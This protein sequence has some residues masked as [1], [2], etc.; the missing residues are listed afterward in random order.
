MT[1]QWHPLPGRCSKYPV[2][3]PSTSK[4]RRLAPR[5][6][7]A[8]VG[9]SRLARIARA[10]P[11]ATELSLAS[12]DGLLEFFVPANADWLDLV[13]STARRHVS[14]PS[15]SELRSALRLAGLHNESNIGLALDVV[16]AATGLTRNEVE[17]AVSR[18]ATEFAPLPGRSTV[19]GVIDEVTFLDDGLATAPLSTIAALEQIGD[20]VALVLIAGGHDRGVDYRDWAD[21]LRRR[22]GPT[23]ILLTGD[24]AERLASELGDTS[25]LP[26]CFVDERGRWSRIRVRP[27]PR[28][29]HRPALTGSAEFRPVSELARPG[30]RTSQ[31]G[32]TKSSL[33]ATVDP[34]ALGDEG[35]PEVD[36]S[37]RT[38]SP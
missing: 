14:A 13:H 21:R 22:T 30:R 36:G 29:R 4:A 17:E 1:P 5:S 32:S 28:W 27:L 26:L 31:L 7:V 19:V 12:R 34:I 33:D 6:D 24:I 23:L 2:F 38:L 9:S 25:Q 11:K 37:S 35:R 16:A 10:L 8:R 20:D 18:R 3:K 15:S